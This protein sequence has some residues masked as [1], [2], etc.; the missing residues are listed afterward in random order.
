MNN[1]KNWIKTVMLVFILL[2]C[3]TPTVYALDED[4]ETD[5]TSEEDYVGKIITLEEYEGEI[6]INNAAG[7][8]LTLRENSKLYNGYSVQTYES[9][10]WISLDKNG[11]IKLDYDTSVIVKKK[12]DELEIILENGSLLF[13][14][15][16]SF[17]DDESL[18]ITSST[19]TTGIRGTLGIASSQTLVDRSTYFSLTLLEG[20]VDLQ[21]VET[22]AKYQELAAQLEAGYRFDLISKMLEDGESDTT[23]N[24]EEIESRLTRLS[25]DDINGFAAIVIK[26]SEEIQNRLLNAGFTQEEIDNII[27]GAEEKLKEDESAISQALDEKNSLNQSNEQTLDTLANPIDPSPTP[28]VTPSPTATSTTVGSDDSTE[29]S[30]TPTVQNYT[31]TYTYK[32]VVFATQTVSENEVISEPLLMPTSAGIW[33]VSDTAYDFSSSVTSNLTLD[34]TDS[35]GSDN[36]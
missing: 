31:V 7:R 36:G 27:E 23:N 17:V 18:K 3:I 14:I 34:W 11:F 5:V 33:M 24:T 12:G 6:T 22:S 13:N 30:T 15:S 29:E 1:F 2:I 21:Y 10:A 19:M 16:E 25:T 26:N 35:S 20:K 32:S 8:E 9:Y 4:V 28:A